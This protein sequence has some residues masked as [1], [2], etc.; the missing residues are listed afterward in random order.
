MSLLK[1]LSLTFYLISGVVYAHS[2]STSTH[3][4]GVT[5]L[6]V[7]T[8]YSAD[9][10]PFRRIIFTPLFTTYSDEN[11][12]NYIAIDNL[13]FS[14]GNIEINFEILNKSN[15][16]IKRYVFTKWA[17]QKDVPNKK[18]IA[19]SLSPIINSQLVEPVDYYRNL[20]GA[21]KSKA[22]LSKLPYNAKFNIGYTGQTPFCSFEFK[23]GSEVF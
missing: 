20:S 3:C 16:I 1:I 9:N 4:D 11:Y 14:S 7:Y 2:N 22:D 10:I 6:K 17:T 5:G 8:D 23:Y 21:D 19:Q 15:Q 12:F 13:K 18:I